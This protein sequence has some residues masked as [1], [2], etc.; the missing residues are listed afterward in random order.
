MDLLYISIE[1][2]DFPIPIYFDGN[3][4]NLRNRIKVFNI[5]INSLSQHILT[6]QAEQQAKNKES[7]IEN[8]LD[9]IS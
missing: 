5:K 9:S 8:A 7:V 2:I 1:N 3:I 6:E 4:D